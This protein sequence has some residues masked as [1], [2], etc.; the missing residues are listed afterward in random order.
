MRTEAFDGCYREVAFYEGDGTKTV[1][2]TNHPGVPVGGYHV[3]SLTGGGSVVVVDQLEVALGEPVGEPLPAEVLRP[4]SR[5]RRGR[6]AA[7]ARS[8]R[9]P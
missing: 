8:R 1:L 9:R 6:R 3:A 2:Y 5:N 4:P 7:E